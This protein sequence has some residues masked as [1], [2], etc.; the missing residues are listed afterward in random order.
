M[1]GCCSYKRSIDDDIHPVMEFVIT[2]DPMMDETDGITD[3]APVPPS[4]D[5]SIGAASGAGTTKG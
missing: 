4:Q 5:D 1:N 3:D 2:G